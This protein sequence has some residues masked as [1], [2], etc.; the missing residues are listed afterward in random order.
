M[1]E[2]RTQ[3]AGRFWK[4]VREG[5]KLLPLGIIVRHKGIALRPFFRGN[6]IELI[7]SHY[8]I[9]LRKYQGAFDN[10]QRSIMR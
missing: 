9:I 3:S 4:G 10:P 8:R 2:S 6:A 1:P 5:R 7:I